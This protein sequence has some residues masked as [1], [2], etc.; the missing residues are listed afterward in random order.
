MAPE[1]A[2]DPELDSVRSA[3]ALAAEAP[4]DIREFETRL[5][6]DGN[7]HAARLELAKA[8]AGH[9]HLDEA[10]DNLLRI[11]ELD[12][13]WN[14]GAAR[15]QLLKVFDAAGPGSETA[16]RGRRRLSSILFS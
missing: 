16:K 15:A 5:A 10:V 4:S 8:L 14:E 11:V 12:R 7:D 13:D 3:L 2:K 1:T 9:G 6:K